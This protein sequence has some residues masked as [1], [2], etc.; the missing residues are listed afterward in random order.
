MLDAD[1]A[2]VHGVATRRLNEQVKRNR[3][4]FPADFMFRLTAGEKAEVVA[5]CDHFARLRFAPS[6]PCAF[7]EHGAIM[8]ASV[9]NS[10]VAIEASVQIVRAFVRLRE[11]FSANKELARRLA[12]LER[13]YDHQF[14]VVFDAIRELM[15]QE[16]LPRRQIEFRASSKGGRG[17][18]PIRSWFESKERPHS[19]VAAGHRLGS[20]L[21]GLYDL[22]T[23]RF[24]VHRGGLRVTAAGDAGA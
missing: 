24:E 8:L 4:R 11:M 18:G 22:R 19:Q 6:L 7:T 23:V 16:Q 21:P 10:R 14:K 15:A 5:N 12:E 13:R 3:D 1:L 9:L 17:T 2:S 20:W